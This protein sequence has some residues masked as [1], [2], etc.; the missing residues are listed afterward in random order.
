MKII[1]L[2]RESHDI[3]NLNNMLVEQ[4]GRKLVESQIKILL[5]ISENSKITKKEMSEVIGISTTAI[6]KNI[7]KLKSLGVLKRIGP[8]KGGY[9]EIVKDE[10]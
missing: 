7:D 2:I 6:D 9:W 4:V 5:L 8:D 10:E 1:E 3:T